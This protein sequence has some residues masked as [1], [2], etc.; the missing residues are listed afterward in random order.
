MYATLVRVTIVIEL[1]SLGDWLVDAMDT[2]ASVY[3]HDWS[4]SSTWSDQ[5]IST[6]G[7]SGHNIHKLCYYHLFNNVWL[8][9]NFK[10]NYIFPE[11][12]S[13]MIPHILSTTEILNNKISITITK[14]EYEHSTKPNQEICWLFAHWN[15]WKPNL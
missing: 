13:S 4:Q 14:L 5:L 15:T 6:K 12:E 11:L 7:S 8:I 3:S 10:E 1:E 9:E 2:S